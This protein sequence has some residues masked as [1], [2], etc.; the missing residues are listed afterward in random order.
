MTEQDSQSTQGREANEAEER[1]R[2]AMAN[3]GPAPDPGLKSQG[4]VSVGPS[5]PTDRHPKPI[6]SAALHDEPAFGATDPAVLR[7]RE[8]DAG[9]PPRAA[10]VP[11]PA[12]PEAS[13]LRP[14]GMSPIED[15]KDPSAWSQPVPHGLGEVG[16]GAV[17]AS[18]PQP[19]IAKEAVGGL[20]E[21]PK[22]D[23]TP[24]SEAG[25]VEQDHPKDRHKER[26][27]DAA[28]EAKKPAKDPEADAEA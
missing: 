1:R 23:G 15:R 8:A 28:P 20:E 18:A 12:G 3:D 2:K 5:Q 24:K 16:T 21:S 27:G 13:T 22:P 10:P 26:A 9:R 17:G 11:K 6:R 7:G 25:V 4:A 19:A 14:G